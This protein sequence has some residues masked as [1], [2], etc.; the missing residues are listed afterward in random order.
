MTKKINYIAQSVISIFRNDDIKAN[1]H[2]TLCQLISC[3]IQYTII[4]LFIF[5]LV[6]SFYF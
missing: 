3:V 1:T 4:T 6:F 2:Y 5:H